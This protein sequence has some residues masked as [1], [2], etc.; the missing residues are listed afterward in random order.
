MDG[1]RKNND[2]LRKSDL[3]TQYKIWKYEWKRVAIW[4]SKNIGAKEN[5]LTETYSRV[6]AD[7]NCRSKHMQSINL[8]KMKPRDPDL[9]NISRLEVGGY[10][11]PDK[12]YV[13]TKKDIS[14]IQFK[15]Q[16]SRDNYESLQKKILAPDADYDKVLFGFQKLG[17][18]KKWTPGPL[19]RRQSSREQSKINMNKR[20]I[21][22]LCSS[23]VKWVDLNSSK[24][25]Y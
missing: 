21:R 23:M 1:N 22:T 10:Y 8:S 19:F 7:S 6:S 20:K 13:L 12:D 9:F 24:L 2:W 16:N 4:A 18:V 14:V 25:F 17:H 15:H 11:N 3:Q 5:C